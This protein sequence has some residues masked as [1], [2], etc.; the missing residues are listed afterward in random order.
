MMRSSWRP[1]LEVV[2]LLVG[3]LAL[4]LAF[5][6]LGRITAGLPMKRDRR[7]LWYRVQPALGF[8]VSLAYLVFA[9]RVVLRHSPDVQAVGV[10]A[11]GMG[12][13]A[14]CWFALR[15]LVAGV[16]LKASLACR[17]G[18]Q[19][20]VFDNEGRIE[21]M[22]LG[23]LTIETREGEQAVIPYRLLTHGTI[24]KTPIIEGSVLYVFQL[25]ANPHASASEVRKVIMER[26]LI[27][28][29]SSVVRQPRVKALG[30]GNYEV[31]VFALHGDYG[32]EI[33][34]LVRHAPLFTDDATP[35]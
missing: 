31:T 2:L 23:A 17:V 6:L 28:H 35:Q 1:E 9:V 29:W 16:V 21:R 5:H 14:A 3:G 15:D 19:V 33:E 34:S 24:H 12:A 8:V 22:G 7:E 18:D 30:D 4:A 10:I 26:A 13:T 27:S 32:P 20:R 11:I 25:K